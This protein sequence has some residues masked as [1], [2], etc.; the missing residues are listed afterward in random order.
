[1]PSFITCLW[2]VVGDHQ[3]ITICPAT[4]VY[5][6]PSISTERKQT[7]TT[8][9]IHLHVSTRI[10]KLLCISCIYS[11]YTVAVYSP[12]SDS[13]YILHVYKNINMHTDQSTKVKIDTVFPRL[14]APYIRI[15]SATPNFTATVFDSQMFNSYYILFN[16]TLFFLQL[17][18]SLFSSPKFK[19]GSMEDCNFHRWTDI[20]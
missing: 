19:G 6:N 5:T 14:F 10:N 4:D 9:H 13:M 2:D 11:V 1:M 17:L 15:N 3:C 8:S 16:F 12:V 20:C 18:L 7:Q